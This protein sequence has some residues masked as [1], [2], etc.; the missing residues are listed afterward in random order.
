MNL[1]T[2]SA[3]RVVGT[4]RFI[5]VQ[6]K[7]V[8]PSILFSSALAESVLYWSAGSLS[9]RLHNENLLGLEVVCAPSEV[10]GTRIKSVDTKN[11]FNED[12]TLRLGLADNEASKE[13]Y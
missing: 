8:S 2:S 10:S 1:F 11:N 6:K 3:L 5:N 9:L 4:P 12:G 7:K 13:R